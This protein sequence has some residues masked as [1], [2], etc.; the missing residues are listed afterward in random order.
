MSKVLTEGQK[1]EVRKQGDDLIEALHQVEEKT[2]WPTRWVWQKA[3][4]KPFMTADCL[5]KQ[6]CKTC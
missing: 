4:S 2:S 6:A 3:I 1:S 5:K